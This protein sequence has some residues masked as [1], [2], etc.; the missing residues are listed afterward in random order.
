MWE[1]LQHLS[2]WDWLALGTLLLIFEIFGAGGY[3]L[4]VGVAA[5]AVGVLTYLIPSLHWTLQFVLFGVLSILTAWLWWRRQRSAARPSD[6]PGLN[7]R[8]HDLLGKTFVVH[9]AIVAGRGKI[10]V[11]DS[12][13]M[14]T[15]PDSEVGTQVRVIGQDGSTLHVERIK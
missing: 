13:W 5:A 7:E 2:F 15:G 10:K 8:G 4:W 9:V 12:V 11:G 1:F 14:A 3:L 6:Q